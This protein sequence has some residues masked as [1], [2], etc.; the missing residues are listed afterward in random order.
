MQRNNAQRA[1][2]EGLTFVAPYDD[3]YTVAGQGSIGDEILRQVGD[4]ARLDAIFV[5]IGG[6]GLIAGVGAFVKALHPHVKIIGVEPSGANAMAMSLARG[7][8]V[9]L[10]KVD[11][12]ADGVAVKHV[13]AETFRLCRDVVDGVVLVDNAAIS[14]AIKDVFNETRS[15]LE[16]AGAVAVRAQGLWWRQAVVAAA[17]GRCWGDQRGCWAAQA[18]PVL[19]LSVLLLLWPAPR[20][21]LGGQAHWCCWVGWYTSLP[22]SSASHSPHLLPP[23]SSAHQINNTTPPHPQVAGAKAWL[24]ATGAKGRTVVAVTS[25]AN[26]NFE[27]LRLVSELADVGSSTEVMLATQIPERPGSFR[28][29]VAVATAGGVSV[30]EFKY[31]Y[32]AG[33]AAAILWSA[34]VPDRAA[35]AALVER[36]NEAGLQT[37]DI[38]DIDAAQVHLRHLVGGRARSYMGELPFERMFQVQFPERPGAL[39]RFLGVLDAAWNVTLFHYRQTGNATSYV[40]LGIQVPPEADADFRRAQR[41]LKDEFG[42][43][44]ITGRAKAVFD[45]FLT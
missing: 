37:S 3:P 2:T 27:R 44:E 23:T 43:Q 28:E 1:V 35:G 4:P 17:A 5:A 25:G 13:G 6:G 45:S 26:I 34:G 21:P 20:R 42:F 22:P 11:G 39:A 9:T 40:L 30:T 38:S 32:S 18:V 7:V 12:F 41:K 14:G 15:I 19:L 10:S 24:K 31:R 16:P 29:F 36:L 33:Q 8:R